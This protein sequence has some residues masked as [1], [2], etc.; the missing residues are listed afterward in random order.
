MLFNDEKANTISAREKD[1]GDA[2]MSTHS[3]TLLF[4]LSL[5]LF[6]LLTTWKLPLY[7]GTLAQK[8][9]M[10]N[11]I[12]NL[13]WIE[14]TVAF[15]KFYRGNVCLKYLWFCGWEKSFV[16]IDDDRKQNYVW[17]SSATTS[18][19]GLSKRYKEFNYCV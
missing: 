8:N 10:Y 14:G 5:E 1:M 16:I 15:W 7:L 19:C 17:F 13:E 6:F 2:W 9:V 4:S 12:R 11:I 3:F 18:E